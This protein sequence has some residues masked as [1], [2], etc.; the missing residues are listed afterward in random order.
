MDDGSI[1]NYEDEITVG[2]VT[3]RASIDDIDRAKLSNLLTVTPDGTVIH[4]LGFPSSE[5]KD[6]LAVWRLVRKLK[7]AEGMPTTMGALAGFN[8]RND[9]L[10]L[11]FVDAEDLKVYSAEG[12]ECQLHPKEVFSQAEAEEIEEAQAAQ[13]EAAEADNELLRNPVFSDELT[14]NLT[15]E[16][17]NVI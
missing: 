4:S 17:A 7:P 6:K 5:R 3:K 14:Q 12:Y 1:I 10:R 9:G 13:N 15:Q 11:D 8:D 16:D 2:E